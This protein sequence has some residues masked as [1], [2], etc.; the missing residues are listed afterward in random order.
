MRLETTSKSL[1]RP[2]HLHDLDFDPCN[3]FY[4]PPTSSIPILVHIGPSVQPPQNVLN[5]FCP[6]FEKNVLQKTKINICFINVETIFNIIVEFIFFFE[7]Q[8]LNRISAF[9]KWQIF[10][11]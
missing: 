9:K 11:V 6:I 2:W 1:L 3:W 7:L 4:T 5:W 8:K 10:N